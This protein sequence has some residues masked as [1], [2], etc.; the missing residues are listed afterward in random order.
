MKL[1]LKSRGEQ[2][3]DLANYPAAKG[4]RSDHMKEHLQPRDWHRD[5]ERISYFFP[6]VVEFQ[7][8]FI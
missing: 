4:A 5:I 3:C 2:G 6:Q 1:T 8:Q 7:A